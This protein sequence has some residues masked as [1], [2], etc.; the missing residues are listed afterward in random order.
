MKKKEE[1]FSALGSIDA[2]LILDAAPGQ[3]KHTKKILFRW[4]AAAACFALLIGAV[5]IGISLYTPPVNDRIPISADMEELLYAGNPGGITDRTSSEAPSAPPP[6]STNIVTAKVTSVLPDRY[7]SI[8][9]YSTSGFRILEMETITDLGEVEMPQKFLLLVQEKYYTDFSQYDCI[10]IDGLYQD[11]YEG[12]VLHNAATGSAEAFDLPIFSAFYYSCYYVYAFTDG[13]LDTA[14]W[15][16][17]EHWQKGF[18]ALEKSKNEDGQWEDSPIQRGATLAEAEAILVDN[19]NSKYPFDYPSYYQYRS[20]AS[21]TN[22]QALEAL[23]YIKPF[24]NGIFAYNLYGYLGLYNVSLWYT[25]YLK[26]FPTNESI[27]ISNDGANYSPARFTPQDMEALPELG[28]ALTAVS[29]EYDAGNIKP[30][31]LKE[32]ETVAFLGYAITGKYI[33]C[34]SG[35]YGLVTVRWN[36]EPTQYDVGYRLIDECYYLIAPGEDH[37]R[38]VTAQELIGLFG[39]YAPEIYGGDYDELGR[40]ERDPIILE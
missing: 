20:V 18:T 35:V 8:R 6:R 32:T 5:S 19:I 10:L 27:L 34:N 13:V 38:L 31:H 30:P 22:P 36:Y 39:D 14:M 15:Q 9:S 37:C 12:A 16:S 28:K 21:I 2:Q 23:E 29:A 33:K 7:Q 11:F 26:G 17:T 1:L 24:E 4:V 25:R 3:K 40:T